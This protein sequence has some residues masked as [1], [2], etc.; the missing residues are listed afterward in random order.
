MDWNAF[1]GKFEESNLAFLYQD[2]TA[3]GKMSRFHKF[4]RRIDDPRREFSG[5]AN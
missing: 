2:K 3:A 4:I 5:R 1:F